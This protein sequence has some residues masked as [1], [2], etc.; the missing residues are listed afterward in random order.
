MLDD[1]LDL[2]L[3]PAPKTPWK[4]LIGA[5]LIGFVIGGIVGFGGAILLGGTTEV[6]TD[7]TQEP[8]SNEDARLV[9]ALDPFTVNLR[10]SGGG[11]VLR[12]VVA[13]ELSEDDQ[14]SVVSAT[15]QL[16]DAVLSLASD[17]TFSDLEGIDGKMHFRD[18][19]LGRI[20]RVLAGPR[21][22]RIYLTQ[23]VV[24]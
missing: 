12:M 8:I 24:Q 20:N 9:H 15:A 3:S 16:R 7:V 21:V 13:L 2:D 22:E 6:A 11:R 17:Y 1:D 23:F 14:E 18:E 4:K 10:G 19:L 5:G